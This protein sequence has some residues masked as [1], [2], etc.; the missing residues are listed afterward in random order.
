MRRRYWI[1]A[2]VTLGTCA[3]VS[4]YGGAAAGFTAPPAAAAPLPGPFGR[5]GAV[6]RPAQVLRPSDNCARV[7]AFKR[8]LC[9]PR[10]GTKHVVRVKARRCAAA[11]D[12]CVRGC[13]TRR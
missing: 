5:S 1:V 3:A 7:C 12:R 4:I 6:V 11:Y 9:W 13:D 2:V 8:N 10:T